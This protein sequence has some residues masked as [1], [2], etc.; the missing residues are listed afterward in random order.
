MGNDTFYVTTPIYYVNDKPHIGHAYTTILADVLA[1]F[2]RLLGTPTHF[3]TGTDEHGQKVQ[4]AATENGITP[5]EQCDRTVVRFQ[6]LWRKLEITH[7]DFIRTTEERHRRVVRGILKDL[8]QRGEIYA[9]N[10]EGWYCVPCERFFTEKDLIEAKCPECKRSVEKLVERNYFF[11]MTQHQQWLIDYIE[12]HPE[13]IQPPHRR[14]ETLGFLRKP[15]GDLCISRPK[16]RLNWGIEL[17][18]DSAYVT[19]VWFDALVNYISGVG[20]PDD[21]AT[22]GKWWPATYHLIGKDILT[23]HTVYWPI[24]LKACGVELPR[25]VF[26]HGWWLVGK[27]KMSKSVGNVVNPMDMV[28]KCGVDA[29][30]YFLMAEMTLGQDA[31]FTEQA[32]TVRYNSDLANDL[33]NLASRV[34][35]MVKRDLGGKIPPVP[36]TGEDEKELMELTLGA[37]ARVQE[38]LGT[39]QI[40]RGIA[41][42]LAAVRAANRYFEKMAPWKLAKSD[43][44]AGLSRVLYCGA[45]SLRIVSGLLYPVMPGKMSELRRA[46]GLDDTEITPRLADLAQW[47]KLKPGQ[48]TGDIESLFPR[49]VE[50]KPV[51]TM[52]TIVEPASPAKAPAAK[53]PRTPVSAKPTN[54]TKVAGTDQ[55]GIETFSTVKLRTARITAAEPVK[56]SHKLVRLQVHLGTEDRQIVAGLL[57]HYRPEELVGKTVV[58]VA[59]LEPARLLGIESN[60]MLLAAKTGEHLRLLTVDGALPPGSEVS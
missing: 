56:G 46:L 52:D 37:V 28:E 48:C 50:T 13:F 44:Q 8:Y 14:Q 42:T 12:A 38:S 18:F 10:Y 29:F 45:E 15:L 6:E 27:D 33:G 25:T 36:Q 58:V 34:L 11:R 19:Y 41:D 39:M 55:I 9:S 53:P 1:R 5:Q 31:S 17:P 26:A 21:K 57:P 24:M 40:D 22:F 35:K 60:G 54:L 43:D 51:A 47:G 23:T 59:N 16:T 20:Y 4:R 49:I 2:H 3:L 7:D 30:R 32:F